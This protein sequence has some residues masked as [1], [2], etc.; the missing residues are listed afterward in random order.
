MIEIAEFIDV[1]QSMQKVK[2]SKV[3]AAVLSVCPLL[4]VSRAA[5][6]LLIL[7]KFNVRAGKVYKQNDE[8]F[9]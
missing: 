9:W 2:G 8:K 7:R 3:F 6:K 5:D 4:H 1:N